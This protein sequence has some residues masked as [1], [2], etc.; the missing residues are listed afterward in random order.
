MRLFPRGSEAAVLLETCNDS[1]VQREN[2]ETAGC[3]DDGGVGV[4]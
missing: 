1:I 4:P 2:V 3:V